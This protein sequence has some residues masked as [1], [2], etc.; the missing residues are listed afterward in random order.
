M[1]LILDHYA[2]PTGAMM[3]VTDQDGHIRI[4]EWIDH[5]DRM[6]RLL[7]RQYKSQRPDVVKGAAPTFI[8]DALDAYFNGQITALDDLV[9]ATGGTDFQKTVWRALRTIPA[10]V[11]SSYGDLA[12]KIGN[13]KAVRAVGLANGANPIAIIVPCHRVIGANGT[14]TGYGGGLSRK[15]WLL[16]HEQALPTLL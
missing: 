16:K 11:T 10:G 14:L 3:L 4:F 7:A 8:R 1:K 12:A 9:T 5:Q 6:D 13:P 2:S 15:Q